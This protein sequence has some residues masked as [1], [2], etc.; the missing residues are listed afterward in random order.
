MAQI[1]QTHDA[2]SYSSKREIPLSFSQE[3]LW[4]LDHLEPGNPVYNLALACRLIGKLDIEALEGSVN[5][6]VR[7]H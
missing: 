6:I 4:F 3:R 1:L 2:S 5:E 7:R